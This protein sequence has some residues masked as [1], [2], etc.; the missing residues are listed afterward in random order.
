MC[1]M[2][3]FFAKKQW[4]RMRGELGGRPLRAAM[5]IFYIDLI[6]QH[7]VMYVQ[8]KFL[9]HASQRMTPPNVF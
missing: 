3:H 7:D 9:P 6:L 5:L 2:T 4:N 1:E 8:G